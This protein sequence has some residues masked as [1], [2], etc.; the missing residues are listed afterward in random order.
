MPNRSELKVRVLSAPAAAAPN[1]DIWCIFALCIIGALASI[2]FA[3]YVQS[4]AAWSGACGQS[5]LLLM[6]P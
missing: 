3:A 4:A 2:D 1:V 5:C 6:S